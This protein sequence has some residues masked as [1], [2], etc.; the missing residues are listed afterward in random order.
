M[1]RQRR[2][3]LVAGIVLAIAA[4]LWPT[5]GSG[6]IYYVSASTGSDANSGLS[7]RQPWKSLHRVNC[8]MLAAGDSVLLRRGDTWHEQLRP[9]S[10]GSTGSPIRFA[11]YGDGARPKISGSDV[12]PPDEWL[13]AAEGVYCLAEFA[14]EPTGLWREG[15][16]LSKGPGNGSEEGWWYEEKSRRVCLRSDGAPAAVEVQK[17]DAAIDN[18]GQSHIVYDGLDLL[19]SLEGLRIY[20]WSGTTADIVLQK[21]LI[22]T[23]PSGAGAAVSAGVYVSTH[24]GKVVQLVVRDNEFRPFPQGLNHWGI[25]LARGVDGFVL[26]NNRIAPAGEDAITVW[27]SMR[28]L[29]AGNRGGGNGENTLDVKDSQDVI[30]RGNSAQNDREYNIVVHS[31]DEPDQTRNI[32]ITENRCIRGGAGGSLSAGIALLGVQRTAVRDNLVREAYGAG[33]LV[34]AL[35]R[36][37]GNHVSHNRF[38]DNGIGQRLPAVVWQ[39]PESGRLRP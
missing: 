30:I 19:H 26:E 17:R 1:N 9:G 22:T 27:H 25:Y 20:N 16:R 34:V 38:D 32:Q 23:E 28:G 33:I 4:A 5:A 12:I 8:A 24:D 39:Y 29:I 21:C 18:N 15:E 14:H 7:A 6:T 10:S 31:V 37:S 11:A 13:G 36:S 2:T 35:T 3:G